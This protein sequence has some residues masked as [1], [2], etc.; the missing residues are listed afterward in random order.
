MGDILYLIV[1]L[2]QQLI[3]KNR[4]FILDYC[5]L[6]EFEY[7]HNDYD[8]YVIDTFNYTVIKAFDSL[9]FAKITWIHKERSVFVIYCLRN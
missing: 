7:Y 9:D 2:R 1:L 8:G 6:K 3:A 4:L 5:I